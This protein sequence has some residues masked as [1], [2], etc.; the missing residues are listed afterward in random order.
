M[1]SATREVRIEGVIY[2][3]PASDFPHL[4]V[5]F[6]DGI[7]P[8]VIAA[9]TLEHCLAALRELQRRAQS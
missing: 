5:T 9:G 4:A 2:Y 3:P 8:T 1:K 7:D 6:S